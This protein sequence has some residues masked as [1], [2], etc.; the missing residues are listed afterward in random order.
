MRKN[1]FKIIYKSYKSYLGNFSS[2]VLHITHKSFP[3]KK[4]PWKVSVDVVTP[5]ELK[6]VYGESNEINSD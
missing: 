4:S 6:M 3:Y 5:Q 2:Y 1:S